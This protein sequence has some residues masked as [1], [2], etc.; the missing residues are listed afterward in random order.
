M[1]EQVKYL[2]R[3]S[4]EY[5]DQAE[6]APNRTLKA[7]MKRRAEKYRIAA[8]VVQEIEDDTFVSIARDVDSDEDV[9]SYKS[10]TFR[11]S[12]GWNEGIQTLLKVIGVS[13]EA[14]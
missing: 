7:A 6:I 12:V 11:E 14:V 9:P 8:E 2:Q 3:R 1:S 13:A 5:E 4:K 10:V